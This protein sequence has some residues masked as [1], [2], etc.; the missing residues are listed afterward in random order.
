MNRVEMGSRSGARIFVRVANYIG[1][2]WENPE[3]QAG[4][5]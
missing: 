5:P 1:R 3:P 4:K 2:K